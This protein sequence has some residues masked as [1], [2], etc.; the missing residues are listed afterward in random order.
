MMERMKGRGRSYIQYGQ[1]R[2]SRAMTSSLRLEEG[3]TSVW[4]S[5]WGRSSIA[6]GCPFHL[7]Q[8]TG[9]SEN[10]EPSSPFG[11]DE[12]TLTYWEAAMGYGTRAVCTQ[13]TPS[14]WRRLAV[15]GRSGWAQPRARRREEPSTHGGK[16]PLQRMRCTK[17][18]G[19]TEVVGY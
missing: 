11:R 7:H 3:A 12:G 9:R 19:T 1:Q 8:L 5:V 14:A 2:R 17:R 16:E 15:H 4:V 18:L 6:L 13:S 10:G